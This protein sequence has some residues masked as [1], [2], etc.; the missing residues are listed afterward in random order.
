MAPVL[1]SPDFE[2]YFIIVLFFSKETIAAILTQKKNLK[3]EH[4]IYFMSKCLQ[5]YEL[6]YSPMEKQAFS[7]VKVVSYFKIIF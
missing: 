4:P 2:K 1:I 6:K 3:E 7:L 5:E